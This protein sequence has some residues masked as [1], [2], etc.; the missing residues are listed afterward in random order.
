MGS[1]S[2]V[3]LVTY[4]VWS[5]EHVAVY[6]RMQAIGDLVIKHDPDVIFFQV[7]TPCS[8]YIYISISDR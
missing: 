4:N 1:D 3:K 8:I 6:R 2:K 5:N 7:Q